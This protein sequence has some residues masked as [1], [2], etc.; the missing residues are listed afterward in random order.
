MPILNATQIAAAA[1][2][3]AN[4]EFVL[5]GAV[6]N[7]ALDQI[8]AAVTAIDTAMADSPATFAALLTGT[9]S[10]NAN[11]GSVFGSLVAAAVP[12]STENQQGAM[13]IYWIQQVLGGIHV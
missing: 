5:A 1:R 8:E 3:F 13:L 6:A 11:V 12:G 10:G 2:N 7:L 9:Y 4:V